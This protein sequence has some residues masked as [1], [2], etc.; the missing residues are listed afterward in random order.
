MANSIP[1]F[2]RMLDLFSEQGSGGLGMYPR[3]LSPLRH[4]DPDWLQWK[5]LSFPKD[6]WVGSSTISVQELIRQ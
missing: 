2:Y 3:S 5:R 6:R 1:G 4:T